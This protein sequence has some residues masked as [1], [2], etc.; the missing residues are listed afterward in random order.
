MFKVLKALCEE[1]LNFKRLDKQFKDKKQW[2]EG[3]PK[4]KTISQIFKERG[5][6]EVLGTIKGEEM[7]GW[8]YEGPY[9]HLEAQDIPG[10]YPYVDESLEIQG[11]TSR[12]QHQVVNPGKDNVG[13]DI[14]VAGEGTGI[15]HMAP[16]C[17][18]IDNK[19]GKKL[20]IVSLAPL[21][22]ESRFTDKFGWLAGKC[23]TDKE[24]VEEILSDL[25]KRDFL[26]YVEE[27]PHI[28]PHCWR[29]GDE[30]VFRLVDEW[31]IN[32]DWRG[33]IKKIVD[34][35]NWI[36]E[37]GQEREHEWLDNMGD[38]MIS[39]KRFWGL[40]LPIWTFD[41]D[42]YYVVGSKQEL[43]DLA[44]EGWDEFEG[45]TPHRPWIDKVKIKHPVSGLYKKSYSSRISVGNFED[46]F[47]NINEADWIIGM[48]G[49]RL[50]LLLNHFQ[51]N[52]E[53][54]SI[55]F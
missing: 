30:L 27:Y 21:D 52:L 31:Y 47:E 12:S 42:S 1:N 3:V 50:N 15:V 6:F 19:I 20:G 28:Y 22:E 45:N 13:N 44:V 32:M 25:K 7:V 37:W 34:D 49:S 4:L 23:A 48:N 14:V 33:K 43:K 16:G 53:T 41:D 51:G 46:H 8:T 9:D 40:A 29:S 17:G 18:D 10:G 24:T 11:V 36:P 54:G 26:V 38:W 35:I 5:G 39:K 55:H 2:L